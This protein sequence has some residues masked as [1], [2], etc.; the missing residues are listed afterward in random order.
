ML[1]TSKY[2]INAILDDYRSNGTH[3]GNHN[4]F[5]VDSAP[6][7]GNYERPYMEESYSFSSF[8]LLL[9]KSCFIFYVN[10]IENALV[11]DVNLSSVVVGSVL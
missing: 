9:L 7:I 6:L 4:T 8:F 3:Q 1:I 2:A 10:S 11:N 5:N